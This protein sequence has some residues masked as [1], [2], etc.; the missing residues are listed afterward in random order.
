MDAEQSKPFDLL[1]GRRTYDLWA[2]FWP[3]ADSVPGADR[4]NGATKYVAT[5]TPETLAWGPSEDVDQD[6]VE[7]IRRV[8]AKDGPGILWFWIRYSVS[9]Y[10]DFAE[11]GEMCDVPHHQSQN[12]T[13]QG[14]ETTLCLP[15]L[16]RPRREPSRT[17]PDSA[18]SAL[19]ESRAAGRSVLRSRRRCNSAP[20]TKAC[21]GCTCRTTCGAHP[22]PSTAGSRA[23]APR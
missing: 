4:F 8:K 2:G 20:T 10:P 14:G 1:L 3:T 15:V 12:N 18:H 22:R 23:S 21:A 16:H 11:E 13:G 5:H 9:S 7:D 17:V 6:I 19:P